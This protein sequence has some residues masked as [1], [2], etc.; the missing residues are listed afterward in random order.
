M[1]GKKAIGQTTS[2]QLCLNGPSHEYN[3]YLVL[4]ETGHALGL[5]H[6]HQHPDAED[7]LDRDVVVDDLARKRFK[8]NRLKA[9]EYY[10]RNWAKSGIRDNNGPDYDPDS[11][12]R[13]E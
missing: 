7:I 11:V 3:R 2:M 4:H 12:M 9:E 13:Y 1:I 6:E 5:Y 10:D 8:G